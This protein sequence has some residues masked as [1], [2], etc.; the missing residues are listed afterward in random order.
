MARPAWSRT[1]PS[2]ATLG[3]LMRSWHAARD[4]ARLLWYGASH[5]FGGKPID[6]SVQLTTEFIPLAALLKF[7]GVVESG[8]QAKLLIQGRRVLVNGEIEVRRAA[9]IRPGDEVVVDV[10]PRVRV[11][12]EAAPE[13]TA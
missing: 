8:G 6:T 12:I 9:K 11:S 3:I 5:H 1:W 10:E 4:F 7:A 13:Q 2:S